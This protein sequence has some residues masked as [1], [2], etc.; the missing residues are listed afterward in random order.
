MAKQILFGY[1][2]DW[3]V[4]I[5]R[6]ID[7]DR[8]NPSFAP[9]E[10][11]DLAAFDLVVP[12]TLHQYWPVRGRDDISTLVPSV[13]AAALCDDKLAFARWMIAQGFGDVAPALIAQDAITYPHVVKP[14]HG[15]FGRIVHGPAQ[16][17]PVPDESAAFRQ[18]AI[19]GLN[20]FVLH[21][22]RVGTSIVYHQ[23]YRYGMEAPLLV[24]GGDRAPLDCAEMDP[25]PALPVAETILAALDYQGTCCLNY[26]FDAR[27]NMKIL[28][29]NPRFVT[30]KAACP[31]SADSQLSQDRHHIAF[32]T[33]LPRHPDVNAE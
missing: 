23:C 28:E 22:V 15:E 27:G 4:E 17:G 2:P 20:E 26:K 9:F 18:Q 11:V 12:L 14:R 5:S 1:H 30:W 10:H 21:L 19:P 33:S 6:L 16:E 32:Q 13:E 7:H 24:R 29:I 25:G 31:R 3:M 8:F